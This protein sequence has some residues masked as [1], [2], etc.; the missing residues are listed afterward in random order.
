D[1][2][3]YQMVL[4]SLLPEMGDAVQHYADSIAGYGIPALNRLLVDHVSDSVKVTIQS[5]TSAPR[6]VGPDWTMLEKLGL[7]PQLQ[8]ETDIGLIVIELDPL[9][10]PATVSAL[11]RLAEAGSYN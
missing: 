7:N 11:V 5:A 6:M 2:E 4:P 10:A 8:F 3:V 9:R 1:I